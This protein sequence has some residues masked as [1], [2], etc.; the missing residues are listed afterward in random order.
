MPGRGRT[1]GPGRNVSPRNSGGVGIGSVDERHRVAADAVQ[2]LPGEHQRRRRRPR[3]PVTVNANSANGSAELKESAVSSTS[4]NEAEGFERQIDR[5]QSAGRR[6]APAENGHR[7]RCR[8]ACDRRERQSADRLQELGAVDRRVD[9][10]PGPGQAFRR[11]RSTVGG[12]CSPG[13][14]LRRLP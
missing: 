7:N 5:A 1:R 12:C 6:P 9:R 13:P 14:I 10:H 4:S 8:T 3:V 11:S 2:V